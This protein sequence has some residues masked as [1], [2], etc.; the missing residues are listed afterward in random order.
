MYSKGKRIEELFPPKQ[1]PTSFIVSNNIPE[2]KVPSLF[3]VMYNEEKKTECERT[4]KTV[5]NELL[6]NVFKSLEFEKY[7][8]LINNILNNQKKEKLTFNFNFDN[9]VHT[10]FYENNISI[11]NIQFSHIFESTLQQSK[12]TIWF[13][14]RSLRLTASKAHLVKI[15]LKNFEKLVDNLIIQTPMYGKG[16]T[17][18]NYGTKNEKMALQKYVD[19]YKHKVIDCG[20]VIHTLTPWLCA[21][22]DGIVVSNKISS[23]VLEIKCPISCQNKP[24]ID[25]TGVLN[26]SYLI[27]DSNNKIVLKKSHIYFTQCQ[28]LMYCCGLNYCDLFIYSENFNSLL[29]EVSRDDLFLKNI[30]Q[31][32]GDFYFKYYLKKCIINFGL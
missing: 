19:L 18:V 3:S 7:A 17:N 1:P 6:E 9:K 15:R 4:V 2:F 28:I 31:K 25:E 29:I 8:F 32:L 21:S 24:I 5:V 30:V 22:P 20:L 12:T 27:R 10:T 16:L 13:G 14:E 11:T 23:K 26:L